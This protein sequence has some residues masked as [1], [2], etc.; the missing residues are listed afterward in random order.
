MDPD[1]PPLIVGVGGEIEEGLWLYSFVRAIDQLPGFVAVLSF[2]RPRD[3]V[4]CVEVTVTY[5]PALQ[6][7]DD[8]KP[9]LVNRLLSQPPPT[10]TPDGGITA[11][12]VRL[13]KVGD[14]QAQARARLAFS[15]AP[16]WDDAEK[17]RGPRRRQDRYYAELAQRYVHKVEQEGSVDPAIALA[18][19]DFVSVAAMRNRLGTARNRGFLTRPGRGRIGGYL[20]P[21][22][23]QVL[24]ETED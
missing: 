23:R 24:D 21:A 19:E 5:D 22:G 14:F 8:L 17:R 12:M 16:G 4:E 9:W 7:E 1:L 2:A 15:S 3:R 18:A 6:T 11:R 20:T 13:L 10:D